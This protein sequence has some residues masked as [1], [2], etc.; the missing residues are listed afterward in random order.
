MNIYRNSSEEVL[1][2]MLK[3]HAQ[4]LGYEIVR[5]HML[6]SKKSSKIQIMIERLDGKNIC[7]KDCEKVSRA[8]GAI[9][10][11]EDSINSKYNLEISSTGLNRPL[12]RKKDYVANV[13]ENIKVSTYNLIGNSKSFVGKL[14][15]CTELGIE[16]IIPDG[17]K[18]V[19][20]EFDSIKDAMLLKI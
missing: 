15:S 9:L 18:V 8:F 2:N 5:L 13:N 17:G 19:Q 10:D 3:G 20:I 12:T 6:N 16:L 11:I 1:Y 4:K 14:A 7:I